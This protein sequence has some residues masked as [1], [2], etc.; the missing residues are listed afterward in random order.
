MLTAAAETP[1]MRPILQRGPRRRIGDSSSPRG[2]RRRLH[3]AAVHCR[4]VWSVPRG[5][6][7]R[8]RDQRVD[9][10]DLRRAAGVVRLGFVAS[11]VRSRSSMAWSLRQAAEPRTAY[12]RIRTSAEMP[13][14]VV[15]RRSAGNPLCLRRYATVPCLFVQDVHASAFMPAASRGSMVFSCGQHCRCSLC[16]AWWLSCERGRSQS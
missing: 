6:S 16:E 4:V 15:S 11:H 7:N 9:R 3:A 13:R 10:H 12:R 2:L 8:S 14:P 1:F 5:V